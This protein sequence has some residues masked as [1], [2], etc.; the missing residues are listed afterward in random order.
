MDDRKGIHRPVGHKEGEREADS[1]RIEDFL[2]EVVHL[3]GYEIFVEDKVKGLIA[4]FESL[5]GH[6]VHK[7]R[8]FLSDL[9]DRVSLQMPHPSI[10]PQTAIPETKEPQLQ[11]FSEF[12]QALTNMEE[13]EIEGF[14]PESQNS[15]QLEQTLSDL[16]KTGQRNLNDEEI[17]KLKLEHDRLQEMWRKEKNS[18]KNKKPRKSVQITYNKPRKAVIRNRVKKLKSQQD[19]EN[20]KILEESQRQIDNQNYWSNESPWTIE[21]AKTLKKIV[22]KVYSNTD[23]RYFKDH[24]SITVH[25]NPLLF[26]FKRSGNESMLYFKVDSNFVDEIRTILDE[27]NL[28]NIVKDG[29]FELTIDKEKILS[30]E[31]LFQK[32]LEKLQKVNMTKGRVKRF[33]EQKGYGFIKVE[34]YQDVFVNHSAIDAGGLTSLQKGD[35]VEFEIAQGPRGPQAVNLKMVKH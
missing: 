8:L 21:N 19:K 9:Y 18:A 30:N 6:N 29:T 23:L 1:K 35:E 31:D 11:S 4:Q 22:D 2:G 12:K 14:T 7:K 24:I 33:S 26:F 34:G 25:N 13:G 17:R 28:T 32:L 10:I 3:T 27:G 5:F 15:R 16:I 20:E